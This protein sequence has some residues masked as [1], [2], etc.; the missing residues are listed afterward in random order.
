MTTRLNEGPTHAAGNG[1]SR[2]RLVA[3]VGVVLLLVV[4]ALG[5]RL[6]LAGPVEWSL[7]DPTSAVLLLARALAG[8]LSVWVGTT[9]VVELV[10]QLRRGIVDPEA[11]RGIRAPISMLVSRALSKRLAGV[12]LVSSLAGNM[13]G[14]AGAASRSDTTTVVLTDRPPA[15]R[16]SAVQQ[17]PEPGSGSARIDPDAPDL[18]AHNGRVAKPAP[19][20][21]FPS[22]TAAAPSTHPTTRLAGTTSIP[23]PGRLSIPLGPTVT[24]VR[25]MPPSTQSN[26]HQVSSTSANRSYIVKPGDH[27]WAVAERAVLASN[28]SA[29]ESSVRTYWI[30]LVEANVAK[31]PDPSNPDLLLVGTTL[32]LPPLVF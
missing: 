13:V 25:T 21:V 1:A 5:I 30:R 8:L 4:C 32:V 9:T 11:I 17:W 12:V 6:A 19:T 3:R 26:S 18:V 10:G 16:G 23:A 28:P 22:G 29:T 2:S 24:P 15:A 20:T 27:F 14:V 31:L 7:G